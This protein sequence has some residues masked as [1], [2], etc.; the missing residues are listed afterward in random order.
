MI[1]YA[2]FLVWETAARSTILV[3]K[4]YVDML[5]DFKAGALL[6]RIVYYY[7]PG[8]GGQP[9]ELRVKRD[10]DFWIAKTRE[11]WQ[12]E[13]FL[14]P[15]E[16][17][18]AV[19]LL[20][21]AG[22]VKKKIFHLSGKPTLH[23]CLIVD[24]FLAGLTDVLLNTYDE[25]KPFFDETGI[26]IL[27]EGKEQ[28]QPLGINNTNDD[29][30]SENVTEVGD[31]EPAAADAPRCPDCGSDKVVAARYDGKRRC[32]YCLLRAAWKYYFPKKSQPRLGTDKYRMSAERRWKSQHFRENYQAALA[33]SA[34]SKTCRDSSW[35]DFWF[36]IRNETNYEKMLPDNFWMEW[37]D[38]KEQGT[39][40]SPL[41]AGQM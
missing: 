8:R 18:R 34:R 27:P 12:D 33:R 9:H 37:K 35:F 15:K 20:V 1:T 29:I 38:A 28:V 7:L 13:V 32:P 36:F 26:S 22:F 25:Y 24:E 39:P 11:E 6:G 2:D 17:D 3:R 5:E 41:G 14:T 16:F 23:I 31:E 4:A 21:D 10:G 30:A 19:K 40:D